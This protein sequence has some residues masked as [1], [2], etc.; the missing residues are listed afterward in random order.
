MTERIISYIAIVLLLAGSFVSCKDKMNDEIDFDPENPIL[1]KWELSYLTG[2]VGPA[3]K[4]CDPT[5]YMKYLPDGL[6]GWY[7]YATK[8]YSLLKCKYRIENVVE[9]N[10]VFGT[11]TDYILIHYQLEDG[12]YVSY[13]VIPDF[14][15][16]GIESCTFI[17]NELMCLHQTCSTGY[18]AFEY[19]HYKRIK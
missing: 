14:L 7:D 6:M 10:P 18:P 2:G 19:A 5:G 12:T 11:I 8:K 1:G 13:D 15:G 16:C 3:K 9:H 17:S 4:T